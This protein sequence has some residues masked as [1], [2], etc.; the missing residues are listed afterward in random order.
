MRSS[1]PKDYRNEA[2]KK[3]TQKLLSM[4]F[5]KSAN[6]VMCYLAACGEVGTEN[7]IKHCIDSGKRLSVPKV[8][9][10]G[11]MAARRIT[12]IDSQLEDG[13]YGIMEPVCSLTA[14]SDPGELDVIILPG[15]AFGTDMH[16]IGYGEGYYDNYL[17]KTRKNAVKVGLAF[18]IQIIDGV[19]AIESDEP[20]DLIIT[21]SKIIGRVPDPQAKTG[22][23]GIA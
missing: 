21:E 9:C 13:R 7:I 17:K 15:V 20:V 1:I 12:C 18:D 23:G 5:F 19:P 2:E 22:N 6:S 4:E 14:E 3:I 11:E 10:K 8:I 16:R